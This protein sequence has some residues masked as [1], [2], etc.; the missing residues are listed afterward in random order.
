MKKQYTCVM[1]SVLGMVGSACTILADTFFVSHRLREVGLAAL[2]IAIVVFGVINGVGLLVGVGCATRYCQQ[3][4]TG[5]TRG[6]RGAFGAGVWLGA[7]F[8][9]ALCLVGATLATGLAPVWGWWCAVWALPPVGRGFARWCPVCSPPTGWAG[10]CRRGW[11]D[12]HR[13]VWRGGVGGI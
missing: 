8:G 7:G 3:T 9:L 11:A 13:A 2:N 12:C 4:T 1:Y 10:C 6:A 5:N